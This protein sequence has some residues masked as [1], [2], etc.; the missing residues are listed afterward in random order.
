[1]FGSSKNIWSFFREPH[2]FIEI[3]FI[4]VDENATAIHGI[5]DILLV[6]ATAVSDF[7]K[8]LRKKQTML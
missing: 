2:Q 3:L 8:A 6:N 5:K 4:N 7:K 1:M